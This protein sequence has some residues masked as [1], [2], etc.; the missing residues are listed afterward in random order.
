MT[1]DP[2][3]PKNRI[4]IRVYGQG[5]GDCILIA[6]KP[7]PNDDRIDYVLVDCGIFMTT[8]GRN[9]RLREVIK[10]VVVATGGK[11]R[12]LAIT[13]EHFDHVAGW[14]QTADEWDAITSIDELWLAWT[15]DPSDEFAP[16]LKKT[17]TYKYKLALGLS[18]QAALS[19]LDEQ[20]AKVFALNVEFSK[21]TNAALKKAI[22]F[23]LDKGAT[24][25]YFEPGETLKLADD[26]QFVFM[27]PPK[28]LKLIYQ[29]DWKSGEPRMSLDAAGNPLSVADQLSLIEL[30]NL[31]LERRLS[32]LGVDPKEDDE[33]VR[34][35]TALGL[36]KK[37][38]EDLPFDMRFALNKDPER[39][40][41]LDRLFPCV[42]GERKHEGKEFESKL[43]YERYE[44][45]PSR[46]ID[47]AGEGDLGRLALQMDNLTN[48]TSLVF[49]IRLGQ[50]YYLFVGDAQVGNWY[51]F[52]ERQYNLG[53]RTLTGE[54]IL[55]STR[56]YKV[57]H[58]G[59]HNATLFAKG[60]DLMPDG[61]VSIVPTE[62][63]RYNGVPD[64]EAGGVLDRL[65]A[66]GP[67][68]RTDHASDQGPFLAGPMS[69]HTGRPLFVEYHP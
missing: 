12:A 33:L 36:N 15:E 2:L 32:D 67:S 43:P 55:R 13:H 44:S 42:G 16:E 69:D 57:G 56:F 49:A 47:G 31:A 65:Q 40:K 5:F 53:D 25:N 50:D 21:A 6:I 68:I 22:R 45:D 52:V 10:N 34:I 64:E 41:T 24:P 58:H 30:D 46:K 27:G 29:D 3:I 18:T 61:L 60:L 38:G 59:S 37:E 19:A 51:G 62:P 9:D 1:S 48:N 66:K 11:L 20:A 17:I 28:D 54:E 4:A 8:K 7:D 63:E 23:A 39:W 26:L 14:Y 35:R